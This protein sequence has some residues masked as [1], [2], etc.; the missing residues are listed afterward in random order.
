[1][2]TVWLGAL[3]AGVLFS[4]TARAACAEPQRGTDEA[5]AFSPPLSQVV[6]GS[7][8][9]QFHSAPNDDCPMKGVF[10][11]PRDKVVTYAQSQGGWSSVMYLNPKTGDDVSGW[12]RS[13]RLRTIGT[14]GPKQ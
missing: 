7:G 5:P 14:V 6:T 12:V 10:I 1:M 13:N 4:H 11:I 2:R 8:R 9:L 3:L